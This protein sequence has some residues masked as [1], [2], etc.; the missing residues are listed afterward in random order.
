MCALTLKMHLVGRLIA[1]VGGAKTQSHPSKQSYLHFDH[2]SSEAKQYQKKIKAQ[3]K[4]RYDLCIEK[5]QNLQKI[6]EEL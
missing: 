4:T 3:P 5:R 2:A 1:P 6:A